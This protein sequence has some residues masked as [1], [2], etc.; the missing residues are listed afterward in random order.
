[1]TI[2]LELAPELELRLREN[3]ARQGQTLEDYLSG[4][5]E[6]D[7]AADEQPPAKPSELL[8][9]WDRMG[10]RPVFDDR[11][12][13]SPQLARK[14]RAEAEQRARRFYATRTS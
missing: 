6:R 1:M 7:S 9:Y 4:L 5:A 2:V 13:D 10:I 11:P 14:W 8:A 12:E 3:A